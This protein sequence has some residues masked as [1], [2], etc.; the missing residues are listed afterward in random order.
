MDGFGA[1]TFQLV[2]GKV[3]IG[4][5]QL[6]ATKPSLDNSATWVVSSWNSTQDLVDALTATVMI[7]CFSDTTAFSIFRNQPVV[8]GEHACLGGP[9]SQPCCRPMPTHTRSSTACLAGQ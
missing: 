5:S 9:G 7:P 3:R 2:N 1:D 6:D 4:L 8:D